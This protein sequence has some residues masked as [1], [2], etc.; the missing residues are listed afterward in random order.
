MKINLGCGNDIR[1]GYI[2]VDRIPQGKNPLDTYRQGD[3]GSLDW[4]TEDATVDEIVAL[5]C[6]EYL[7]INLIKQALTN[8]AQKLSSGGTLKILVPDC[9]AIAK[10]FSQG[11]FNLQEYSQMILGTQEGNDN[12]LSV[13]DAATL[14]STLQE[15][16]LTISLKRYEGVA[17]YVEAVK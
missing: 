7:P 16:G 3:I 14:L 4:L 13:I 9:H 8:W 6:L 1:S 11:Q 5:D 12:R 10:S 2:N 17:I 15:I